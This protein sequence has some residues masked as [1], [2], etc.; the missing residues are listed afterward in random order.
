M[1]SKQ[2]YTLDT[3]GGPRTPK[4]M[5]GISTQPGRM[6]EGRRWGKGGG[7]MGLAPLK[8]GWGEKRFP[9][10]ERAS[11]GTERDLWRIWRSEGNATRVSPTCVGPSEHAGVPGLGPQDPLQP[12]R[13]GA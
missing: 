3:G 12:C 9:L 8:G 1:D 10:T 4:G 5:G 11:A 2:Q 6:W 7:R 13:S